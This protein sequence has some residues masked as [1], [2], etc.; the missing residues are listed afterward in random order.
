MHI[1]SPFAVFVVEISARSN[2]Y[3][4]LVNTAVPHLPLEIP[5]KRMNALRAT[6]VIPHGL[7]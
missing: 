1:S 4:T 6:A 2:V 3:V 5:I 7:R